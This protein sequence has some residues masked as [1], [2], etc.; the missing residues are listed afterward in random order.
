MR[1]VVLPVKSSE[2]SAQMAAM[3]MWLDERRF[4]PS[5]FSCEDGGTAVLLRVEFKVAAEADA[6]AEQFLGG[7]S[8][9]VRAEGA[10]TAPVRAFPS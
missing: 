4:E 10:A 7:R 6:F 8:N 3:R 1:S 5:S 2:L 9:D